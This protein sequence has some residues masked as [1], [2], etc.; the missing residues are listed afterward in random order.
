MPIHAIEAA[1]IG[2]SIVTANTVFIE[3]L[4][5]KARIRIKRDLPRSAVLV[6]DMTRYCSSRVKLNG[7]R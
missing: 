1:D 5:S 4:P 7:A 6:P 3:Q 2:N